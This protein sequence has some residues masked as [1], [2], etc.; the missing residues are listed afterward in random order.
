MWV[1]HE[2][3]LKRARQF[4]NIISAKQRECLGVRLV[5]V[6]SQE[7]IVFFNSRTREL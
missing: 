1:E 6:C 2:S 7:E 3:S 5:V 4:P